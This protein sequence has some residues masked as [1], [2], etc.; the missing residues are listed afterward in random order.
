ME[1][2]IRRQRI[3]V[4]QWEEHPRIGMFHD[5][6]PKIPL[7]KI[8]QYLLRPAGSVRRSAVRHKP[9]RGSTSST[10]PCKAVPSATSCPHADHVRRS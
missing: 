8:L 3:K 9:V 1:Q 4:A 10:A 2:L 7:P 6:L 5:E